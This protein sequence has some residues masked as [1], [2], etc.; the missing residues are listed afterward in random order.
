MVRRP[1]L[2]LSNDDGYSAE[3]L[4]VL[5][6]ALEALGEV[7]V[8]APGSQQSAVSHAV[9]LHRPLRMRRLGE[10]RYSVD[11][12]PTDCVAVGMGY[13]MASAPPDVVV[14]GINFG[15]NMGADVHYSGTVSAAFEGV[16]SGVP[17]VAVSQ[18]IGEGFIYHPAARFARTVVEWILEHGLPRDTLLNINV[19][20]VPPRG[21]L[22]TRLGTRRYTEGV[23]RDQDPRGNEI[24]WIGGGEPIWEATPGTD[25]P[26]VAEG[27]ISVTPLHLDMTAGTLLRKLQA[28]PPEWV[29]HGGE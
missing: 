11:G 6:D 20:A 2:L 24:F 1:R 5:A 22:L 19:P 28:D 15:V 27:Y 23:I 14:S 8:V 10:R 25:F 21:V 16:I 7:W 18:Q 17:A 29:N 4:Q 13:L 3:G 12:T 26:A 9:T